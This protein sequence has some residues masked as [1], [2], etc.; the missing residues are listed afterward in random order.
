MRHSFN[1][2]FADGDPADDD[3][4]DEPR[5]TV[6]EAIAAVNARIAE[7]EKATPDAFFADWFEE[8]DAPPRRDR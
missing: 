2:P 8:E 6:A 5:M 4:P 1:S 7:M 3:T